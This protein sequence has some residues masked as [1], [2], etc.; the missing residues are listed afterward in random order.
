MTG[1]FINLRKPSRDPATQLVSTRLIP[2]ATLDRTVITFITPNLIID[3]TVTLDA[4][5]SLQAGYDRKVAKKSTFGTTLLVVL[6]ALGSWMPFNNEVVKTLGFRPIIWRCC[7]GKSRLLAIQGSMRIVASH[8]R[9]NH[10]CLNDASSRPVPPTQLAIQQVYPQAA[11]Q[12]SPSSEC[13]NHASTTEKQPLIIASAP[14]SVSGKTRYLPCPICTH[15]V[16]FVS[17]V[18]LA[19]LSSAELIHPC[20]K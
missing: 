9:S 14:N 6:W 16:L 8:F 2:A 20:M 15:L 19:A 17:F 12:A 18:R 3:L 7:R 11:A 10:E 1:S 13:L 4:P 5:D